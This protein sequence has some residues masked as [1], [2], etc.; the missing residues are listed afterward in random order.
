MISEK[1]QAQREFS[2]AEYRALIDEL[3][4]QNK[5]TGTNHS[6]A[7]L[8]YTNMNIRR[9]DKW[10]KHYQPSQDLTQKIAQ[11]ESAQDW[12]VLTEAWCGDAAHSVPVMAKIAAL[13]PEK[14]NLKIILR[15]EN[16]PIMEQYLTNGGRSIPKLVAFDS[17]SDE[18]LFQWGPRPAELQELR[19]QL[20]EAGKSKD[21]INVELQKWYARDRGASIEREFLEHL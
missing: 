13:D 2:Y 11:L 14:I 7:Y 16:L 20:S 17:Q 9:M 8:N 19:A 4:S 6:E 5:T 21:E 15:D 18:E 3:R 10:D 1:M 12:L